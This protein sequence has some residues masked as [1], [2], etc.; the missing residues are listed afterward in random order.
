MVDTTS[1]GSRR[2]RLEDASP[3]K[4][5]AVIGHKYEV[6]GLLALGG[7]GL[8]A[9]A[10]HQVLDQV[11]AIKFLLPDV[12]APDT[13]ER[14]L[15]EAKAA[16]NIQSEH[17]VR[18]FDCGKLE[19]GI[20]YM[21]ME[22]L[23][24]HSLSQ[25]MRK[26]GRMGIEESV[27]LIMQAL[28]GVAEAHARGIV[29]RDLKPSNLFLVGEWPRQTVKVLDF[30]ISKI[31]VGVD[32]P[33][34]DED[35]THTAMILGSPKY[36]SPEQARSSKDVD[37]TA[38]IWSIGVVLYQLIIGQAP[39][40]GDTI[41]EILSQ[42]LTATPRPLGQVRVDVPPLLTAVVQR[43]LERDPKDRFQSVADLADE[44]APHGSADAKRSL[45]RIFAILEVES[46][47][48]ETRPVIDEPQT[49]I[50]PTHDAQAHGALTA[51]AE[52]T[53]RT[54]ATWEKRAARTGPLGWV[55]GTLMLGAVI[56]GAMGAWRLLRAQPGEANTSIARDGMATAIAV[57]PV[58]PPPSSPVPASMPT[59]SAA[60]TDAQTPAETTTR[61]PRPRPFVRP[62]PK[63][64]PDPQP[65]ASPPKGIDPLEHSD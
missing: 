56:A 61:V 65:P 52:R 58:A 10:R 35:L 27:D 33:V 6:T 57:P 23:E 37:R 18:V 45:E 63:P 50:T 36:I 49:W 7:M 29:H 5:G 15:R 20:P 44:L 59:A 53:Q 14:F 54:V 42:I 8:V 22:Y 4:V 48:R 3:V 51:E 24:G 31:P 2:K 39:F 55:L 21:V 11:V 40:A 9:S 16:A 1:R 28:Q 34:D 41:G 13:T 32:T 17:V 26:R 43:C 62:V 30:G 25:A 19:S 38:D 60:S 46:A 47:E 64:A 12:E